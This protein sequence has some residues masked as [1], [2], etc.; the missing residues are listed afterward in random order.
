MLAWF[1]NRR[2]PR[3]TAHKLY[4]SIVAQAREPWFYRR[5]NVPDTL[6]CR[7]EIL[8][9][10]VYVVLD[11]LRSDETC[12]PLAQALVDGFF[13]DMDVIHRE[14]GVAD[15]KV[16]KNMHRTAGVFYERLDHYAKAFAG[17]S[18]RSAGALL[19][20]C[21]FPDG[22][23]SDDINALGGYVTELHKSL[24]QQDPVALKQGHVTFPKLTE[25]QASTSVREAG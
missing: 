10:H 19:A 20:S 23:E 11:R 3:Q 15:L 24:E 6:E 1:T 4:G 8:V 22:G 17:A 5:I 12:A 18:E 25:Q 16:P 14:L 13:D 21:V 7:F 2:Q 9:L